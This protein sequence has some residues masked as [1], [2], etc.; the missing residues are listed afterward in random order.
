ML[1]ICYGAGPHD[2]HQRASWGLDET[3]HHTCECNVLPLD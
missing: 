1:A 3:L 2:G